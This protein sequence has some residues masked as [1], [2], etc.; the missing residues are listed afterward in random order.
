[1]LL[2]SWGGDE[3][4]PERAVSWRG[5]RNVLSFGGNILKGAEDLFSLGGSLEGGIG[6]I[7]FWWQYVCFERVLKN[8][9]WHHLKKDL[10]KANV[11]D[12]FIS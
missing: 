1:M 7:K 10:G 4:W 11:R 6:F 12:L 9:E 5:Y 2:A 3:L 8:C